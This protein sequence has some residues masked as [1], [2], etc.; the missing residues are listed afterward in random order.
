MNLESQSA[1]KNVVAAQLAILLVAT[2]IL[3]Q[4]VT[5]GE[6][7]TGGLWAKL[8]FLAR[9]AALVAFA[10]WM[11]RQ[12]SLGWSDVGLKRPEWRRFLIALP[13]GLLIAVVFSK[14]TAAVLMHAGIKSPDLSMFA[15]IRGNLGEY[16]F[17]LLPASVG[18]AAFG[19]EMLFRGFITDTLCR[20]LKGR[21]IFASMIAITAQAFIFGALHY[22]QGLGGTV[23]AGAIGLALGLTWLISGRNLWAGIIIHALLDGAGMTAIYLGYATA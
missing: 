18:T 9:V 12:R 6:A 11:L 17:W 13:A 7:V 10:T 16:L 23:V 3:I 19:E 5:P 15:P 21:G 14:V 20:L 4:A 8:A 1:T 2:V 22:Y